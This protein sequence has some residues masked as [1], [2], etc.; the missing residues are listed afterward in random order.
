LAA[1]LNAEAPTRIILFWGPAEAG[2]KEAYAR[3]PDATAEY[4]GP[5][6]VTKLAAWFRSCDLMICNDTGV[7]HLAAAVGVPTVALFGPTDPQEWTPKGDHVRS[8][9]GKDQAVNS[10]TVEEVATAVRALVTT[11]PPPERERR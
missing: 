6:P 4:A 8:V 10:I 5:M 3:H 7:M 11:F 2:L 1:R 9:A